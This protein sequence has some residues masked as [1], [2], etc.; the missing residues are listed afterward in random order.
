MLDGN[1]SVRAG[2]KRGGWD[3]AWLLISDQCTDARMAAAKSPPAKAAEK[4]AHRTRRDLG[5]GVTNQTRLSMN[6]RGLSNDFH[7]R[8]QQCV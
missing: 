7:P 4:R 6:Q 5:L 3:L 8:N 1:L 2:R